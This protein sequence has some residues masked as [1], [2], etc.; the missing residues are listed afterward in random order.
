MKKLIDT[1]KFETTYH[2]S[3]GYYIILESYLFRIIS[4]KG[5]FCKSVTDTMN[6]HIYAN[7]NFTADLQYIRKLDSTYNNNQCIFIY[8]PVHFISNEKIE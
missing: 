4:I 2:V 3:V 6:L 1:L 5:H 8:N 7:V